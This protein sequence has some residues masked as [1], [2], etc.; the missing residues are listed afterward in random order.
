MQS[1]GCC[2]AAKGLKMRKRKVVHNNF[3]RGIVSRGMPLEQPQIHVHGHAQRTDGV[4]RVIAGSRSDLIGVAALK[5]AE[6]LEVNRR[7]IIPFKTLR[8]IGTG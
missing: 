3:H 6:F 2:L 8:G 5:A 1:N 4:R 7:V